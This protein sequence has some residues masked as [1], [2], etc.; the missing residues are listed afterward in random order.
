M[1][2]TITNITNIYNSFVDLM[3]NNVPSICIN[4]INIVMGDSV[5]ITQELSGFQGI[6]GIIVKI[7]LEAMNYI[8]DTEYISESNNTVPYISIVDKTSM[9]VS[10]NDLMIEWQMAT[11]AAYN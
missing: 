4:D 9:T 3:I 1:T 8:I 7:K 5:T 2:Y 11:M 10:L 6:K